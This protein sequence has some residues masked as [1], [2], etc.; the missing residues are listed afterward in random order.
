MKKYSMYTFAVAMLAGM[1]LTG[2]SSSEEIPGGTPDNGPKLKIETRSAD[3]AEAAYAH[4][5]ILVSEGNIA[6]AKSAAD[7][8]AL[9]S[10]SVEPAATPFTP[11]LPATR[12]ISLFRVSPLRM[13]LPMH[14]SK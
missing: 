1:I 4:R 13:P 8:A 11:S 9:G 6:D 2:C 14:V 10:F 12:R 3:A 5:A 7:A